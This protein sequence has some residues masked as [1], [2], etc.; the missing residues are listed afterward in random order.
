MEDLEVQETNETDGFIKVTA[1]LLGI[2]SDQVMTLYNS[3][4][5]E[6]KS[7]IK[8]YL[9]TDL[10]KVKPNIEGIINKYLK[11]ESN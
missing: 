7:I 10:D 9:I 2:K 4:S 11:N 8:E 5:E 3:C 6:E 1:H